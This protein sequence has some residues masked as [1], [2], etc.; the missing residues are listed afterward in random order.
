MVGPGRAEDPLDA[1]TQGLVDSILEG[2][3]RSKEDSQPTCAECREGQ[4]RD[5]HR[6]DF[7]SGHVQV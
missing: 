2:G 6:R 1:G 3:R 4:L 7:S 5:I